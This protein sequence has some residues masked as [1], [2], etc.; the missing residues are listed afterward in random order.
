MYRAIVLEPEYEGNAGFIARLAENFDIDELV[1]VN[2]QC[3]FGTEAE[4]RAS[5][6]ADRLRSSRV[7]EDLEDA[8]GGLDFLIGTT[9]I[10]PSEDNVLRSGIGPGEMAE[11]IPEDAA[12]GILLGREGK[13][14]SNEELDLCDFV[15]SIPT[16]EDY[17]VMNL[18]HAAAVVFYKLYTADEAD[19]SSSS[20]ERRQVLENLFKGVTESLDWNESRKEK[21]LRAFRNVLGRAYA[22]DRELQ[23]LLGAFRELGENRE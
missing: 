20:R 1:F 8:I 12:V 15:V 16:S 2:P 9:G 19:R 6:A 10:K 3:D 17:P 21:T 7:V 13:G 5:H 11:K 23:L 4:A 18:S 22:T 14:L